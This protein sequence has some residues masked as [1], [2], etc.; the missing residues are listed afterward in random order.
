MTNDDARNYRSR[1]VKPLPDIGGR[2]AGATLRPLTGA[3]G[4]VAGAGISLE[5]YAVDRLLDTGEL[6]WCSPS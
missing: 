1:P 6:M 2:A 5:Q 3:V 4:A